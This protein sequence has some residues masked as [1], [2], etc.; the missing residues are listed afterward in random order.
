[1]GGSGAW[2]VMGCMGILSGLGKPT[3]HPSGLFLE[4][5]SAWLSSG[6]V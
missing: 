1:M 2:Y 5:L 3:E 4:G 6:C